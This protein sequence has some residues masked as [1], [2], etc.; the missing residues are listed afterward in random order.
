M[1]LKTRSVR[2]V[3]YRIASQLPHVP[4]HAITDDE[5]I[6]YSQFIEKILLAG[7]F[8]MEILP[9]HNS[10]FVFSEHGAWLSSLVLF[11]V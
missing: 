1:D 3:Y 8:Y 9:L 5:V 10:G 11:N 2:R 6:I 7:A 4:L